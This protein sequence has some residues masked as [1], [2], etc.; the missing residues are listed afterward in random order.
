MINTHQL[1]SDRVPHQLVRALL[2]G[3]RCDFD[4]TTDLPDGALG[5]RVARGARAT[6]GPV[7]I[8]FDRRSLI[9]C[10]VCRAPG[11]TADAGDAPAFGAPPLFDARRTHQLFVVFAAL[12]QLAAERII[13]GGVTDQ[14]DQSWAVGLRPNLL[15]HPLWGRPAQAA[16]RRF[17]TWPLLGPHLLQL[18]GLARGSQPPPCGTRLLGRRLHHCSCASLQVRLVAARAVHLVRLPSRP[19]CVG[20]AQPMKAVVAGGSAGA[21]NE[22]ACRGAAGPRTLRGHPGACETTEQEEQH[23]GRLQNRS[24]V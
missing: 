5:F 21:L 6:L 17:F 22:N 11:G 12:G 19:R 20:E 14:L 16:H 1:G 9:T 7:R 10:P 18:Q 13:P 2:R 8:E 23:E 3:G 24:L 4:H 15:L